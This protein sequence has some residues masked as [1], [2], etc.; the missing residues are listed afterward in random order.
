MLIRDTNI[1]IDRAR[2]IACGIC[3]VRCILDNLRL[4]V[5]PCRQSCPLH[6]NCQG[7]MRLIA[8]GQE[9]EAMGTVQAVWP[10]L[11][12]LGLFCH[13]PCEKSCARTTV[14]GPVKIRAQHRYLAEWWSKFTA[15]DSQA[16]EAQS[17]CKIAIWGSGPAG[18]MAAWQ[19]SREG[20]RTVVFESGKEPGGTLR[21]EVSTSETH[22]QAI[23]ALIDTVSANGLE[24]RLNTA[25][26]EDVNFDDLLTAYD[27]LVI[28]G[29]VD[30]ESSSGPVDSPI[31]SE[32]T[33]RVDPVTLQVADRK[34]IFI[35]R[36]IRAKGTLLAN[37]LAMGRAAAESAHRF[38]SGVPL[39]WER[40]FWHARGN[41]KDYAPPYERTKHVRPDLKKAGLSRKITEEPKIVPGLTTEEAVFEAERCLGC[42]RP[43]DHNQ[44]CW[45][46]LPCEIECPYDALEVRIPYLLR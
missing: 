13:A 44:T 42:G 20:H 31:T 17:G 7:F 27:A 22:H 14:D 18:L 35:C 29:R 40:G 5:A 8:Q 10:F 9:E 28:T 23:D 32:I 6:L 43:F 39:M 24:I 4:S 45:Y 19:L 30:W 26:G 41:V 36:E 25:L 2:C 34:K 38:L 15:K 37:A 21:N 46:C 12:I 33:R 3:V 1:R 11:E 16:P